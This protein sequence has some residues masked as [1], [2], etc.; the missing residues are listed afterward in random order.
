[1]TSWAGRGPYQAGMRLG[2]ADG[3]R[4]VG[5]SL[6]TV[7]C[8]RTRTTELAKE[9]LVTTTSVSAAA[10][11]TLYG[12]PRQGP[13]RELKKEIE[14]YWK[15][16]VGVSE[17][18]RTAADLRAAVWDSRRTCRSAARTGSLTWTS[19]CLTRYASC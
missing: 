9:S 17:L 19:R 16:R 7:E 6:R 15:G 10:R 13:D 4:L 8:L 14:G 11:A 18:H 3:V 5:V 12:Y 1:M 2:T